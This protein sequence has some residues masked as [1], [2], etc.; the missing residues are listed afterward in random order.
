MDICAG[1]TAELL[2]SQGT[3]TQ[4]SSTTPSK[5]ERAALAAADV[6]MNGLPDEA[7]S[8]VALACLGATAAS[9]ILAALAA[10]S[11][12]DL[13]R[14]TKQQL[15]VAAVSA[16]VNVISQWRVLDIRKRPNLGGY[17]AASSG[18]VSGN[19]YAFWS[20]SITLQSL[21]VVMLRGPLPSG[22][23]S[24]LFVGD[25]EDGSIMWWVPL[26]TFV[27]ILAG[28]T[29][30]SLVPAACVRTLECSSS[31][32]CAGDTTDK[33]ASDAA[34]IECAL[35]AALV[36]LSV[37]CMLLAAVLGSLAYAVIDEAVDGSS[38]T[39]AEYE[40]A[41]FQA[42]TWIGVPII[43][44]F[45]AATGFLF[46]ALRAWSVCVW[47]TAPTGD[48]V[49]MDCDTFICKQL[50]EWMSLLT[51]R[52]RALEGHEACSRDPYSAGHTEAH[53]LPAMETVCGAQLLDFVAQICDV[54]VHGGASMGTVVLAMRL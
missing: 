37:A 53:H 38:R 18:L 29:A 15:L 41:L 47:T 2:S 12:D 13:D 3:H 14:R 9:S 11:L 10:L 42:S 44:A 6:H 33:A 16:A 20:T 32:M 7:V 40:F 19:R 21:L 48:E 4:H 22:K 50:I 36:A 31:S 43:S 17:T 39:K 8:T 5:G 51:S 24:L 52:G 25:I 26:L 35:T 34:R 23:V 46:A 28:G 54:V 45:G 27:S 49:V 1:S 30:S